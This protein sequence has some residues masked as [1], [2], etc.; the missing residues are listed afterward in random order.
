MEGKWTEQGEVGKGSDSQRL[1]RGCKGVKKPA[2]IS[3]V[4]W[5]RVFSSHTKGPLLIDT[6]SF[7]YKNDEICTR[8]YMEMTGKLHFEAGTGVSK[9]RSFHCLWIAP[10]L[11]WASRCA[12]TYFSGHSVRTLWWFTHRK[13]S[14]AVSASNPIVTSRTDYE[15]IFLYTFMNEKCMIISTS[16]KDQWLTIQWS[17]LCFSE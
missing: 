9:L 2:A 7:K 6:M 10:A 5:I 11:V 3:K 12:A 15:D 4:A 14:P 13:T 17:I 16:V 8:T 1:G